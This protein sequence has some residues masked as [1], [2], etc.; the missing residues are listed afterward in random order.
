MKTKVLY[1]VKWKNTEVGY[2]ITNDKKEFKYIPNIE[3]IKELAKEGMPCTLVIN[4]Q[5]EW[6]KTL[7]KY[8]AN[9][10]KLGTPQK[11]LITDYFS[12]EEMV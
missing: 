5:R 12:I 1:T 7:P 2:V 9:R 4:P 3:N 11:R 10:L 8:I 6:K